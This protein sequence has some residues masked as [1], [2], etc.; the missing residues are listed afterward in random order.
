MC[1]FLR[2]CEVEGFKQQ[3]LNEENCREIF[4]QYPSNNRSSSN[5][6]E[7]EGGGQIQSQNNHVGWEIP[8][9]VTLFMVPTGFTRGVYDDDDG[10]RNNNSADDQNEIEEEEDGMIVFNGGEFKRNTHL[11][12]ESSASSSLED[13]QPRGGDGRVQYGRDIEDMIE[14]LDSLPP[15]SSSSKD[16]EQEEN[17]HNKNMETINKEKKKEFQENET[18][19]VEMKL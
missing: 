17:Y 13:R 2:K 14:L 18:Q 4:V 19:E 15:S 9:L 16:K 1:S 12:D 7:N 6:S 8:P 5:H 11:V 10:I 3:I